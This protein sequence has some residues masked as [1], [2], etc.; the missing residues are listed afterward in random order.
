MDT[1]AAETIVA[2]QAHEGRRV[3]RVRGYDIIDCEMC[4]FRHVLPLP[5]PEELEAARRRANTKED[6]ASFSP[7]NSDDRAWADLA[8]ND[9][10]E[11]FEHYLAPQRRRL[12]DV[13][14][15]TGAFLKNA[16]ARGWHV[17]GIEPSRQASAYARKHGVEVAEGFF[18]DET[19]E[20]LGRFDAVNLCNIL[21]CAP[22]PTNIAILARDILDPGGVLCINVPNDF[23]PFQIAACTATG[24]NEWWI[25]PPYHLNYF[26]FYSASGLL[27]RLGLKIVERT[28]SFPME[29]FLMMGD[30]YTKDRTI[31][32]DC[33]GKRKRFDLALESSGF[34]ETRR[35]FY[36]TL[37][38]A[39]MGREAV[40]IAVKQ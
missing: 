19:A 22:D 31:G 23:S 30:D 28:T 8:H 17:L 37:A 29:L 20:G 18:N 4:G 11:S 40:I 1:A 14:S 32:R 7:Q 6:M 3:A 15:G 24:A 10:L 39:G 33:H 38:D 21:E 9:R 2:W 34:K 35:A 5:D 25:A 26:D 12:L 36:R 13:G 16:K 27:E